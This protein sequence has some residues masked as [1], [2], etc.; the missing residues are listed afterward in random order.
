M[1]F[2]KINGNLTAKDRVPVI[3]EMMA[4]RWAYEAL[5]VTQFKE[6]LYNQPIYEYN[7]RSVQAEFKSIY[8]ISEMLDI[9][10]YCQENYDSNE[11]SVQKRVK[12]ELELLQKEVKKELQIVGADQYRLDR[13]EPGSFDYS[14]AQDLK[15]FLET[16]QKFYNKRRNKAHDEKEA[17]PDRDH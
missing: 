6:N 11:E 8:L 13:L 15:E 9:L 1:N 4:S 16:L 14:A 10:E 12:S 5:A 3:G 17:F 2:D 7:R